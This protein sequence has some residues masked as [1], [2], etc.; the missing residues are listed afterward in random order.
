MHTDVK[1]DG[2]LDNFEKVFIPGLL[3]AMVEVPRNV[4]EDQEV[5]HLVIM[6]M[7]TLRNLLMCPKK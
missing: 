5:V 4:K 3:P 1:E 2:L 7:A 6:L